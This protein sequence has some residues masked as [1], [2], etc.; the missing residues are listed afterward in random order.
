M[1]TIKNYKALVAFEKVAKLASYSKAAE[2]L[3]VSKSYLSKLVL[4]LEQELGQRLLNRST[5]TVKLTKAGKKLFM[6]CHINFN[7]INKIQNEIQSNS[8]LP[9]GKLKISVAG[10]FGEEFVAPLTFN[11]LKKYPNIKIQLIFEENLIDLLKDSYD[12]AIRVGQ[13]KNSSLIS[14]KIATRKAFVCATASYLNTH[15]IPKTPDDL[16][17]HNCLS[18]KTSWNFENKSIR[19][20][21][22][23]KGNYSSNNNRTILQATLSDLGICYLPGE[24]VLPYIKSGELI[25][26]L[27]NYT[28]QE[29]PI[30]LLSPSNENSSKA[31]Q[32]FKNSFFEEI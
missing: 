18:M 12:F 30:W 28:L 23:I 5:R 14:R 26:I 10:A 20:K 19:Q 6:T 2:E 22:Q 8:N 9:S 16:S 32:L 3:A 15:G 31:A 7:E 25:S 13:L 1:E 11:F 17:K 4:K 27:E 29:I 21:I 24:Y